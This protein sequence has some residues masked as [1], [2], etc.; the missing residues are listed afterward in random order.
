MTKRGTAL[1]G[2]LFAMSTPHLD[3]DVPF[4]TFIDVSYRGTTHQAFAAADHNAFNF[5][6]VT[7]EFT[8]G[9]FEGHIIETL[10]AVETQVAH[11]YQAVIKTPNGVLSIHSYDSVD[12]LLGLVGSLR[13]GSTALGIVLNPDDE[14]EYTSAPKVAVTT[15]IGVLEVTPLT[16]E[17]IEQLPAWEGS[18][19]AGGQLYG[20]RFTDSAVYLTLVT[21]TC[22]VLA[23]PGPDI[24]D[25]DVAEVM[26]GLEVDWQT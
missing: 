9:N 10:D 16:A 21:P 1:N 26:A 25:D 18:P 5:A 11:R 4:T 7:G 3:L 14:V 12:G 20:G 17:V 13:P 15:A 24:A 23:L 8:V 19:V 6:A 2:D 22:R